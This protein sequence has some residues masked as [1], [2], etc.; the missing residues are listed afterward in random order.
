MQ[1]QFFVK[2]H[3]WKF[4]WPCR[5]LLPVIHNSQLLSFISI[6]W[7]IWNLSTQIFLSSDRKS[8]H[9]TPVN[10][11][12]MSVHLITYQDSQNSW[13]LLL[14]LSQD[15]N[16]LGM[17]LAYVTTDL[18]PDGNVQ[19]PVHLS[20]IKVIEKHKKKLLKN[21]IRLLLAVEGQCFFFFWFYKKKTNCPKTNGQKQRAIFSDPLLYTMVECIWYTA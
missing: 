15:W 1:L 11:N 2:I 7:F 8:L 5:L 16:V 13:I 12:K 9:I 3:I 18:E 4:G 10:G 17:S 6:P 14:I 20:I 19:S 21:R